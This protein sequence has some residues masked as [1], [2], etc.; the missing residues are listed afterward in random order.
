MKAKLKSKNCPKGKRKT[1][2][3]R[4]ELIN[5]LEAKKIKSYL[6]NSTQIKSY[7]LKRSKKIKKS[8]LQ[9]VKKRKNKKNKL[10]K[11]RK[12]KMETN[13]KSKKVN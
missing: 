4:K 3:R 13:K 10:K 5:I 2:I 1:R 11:R 6:R 7:S 12:I 8:N 9:K